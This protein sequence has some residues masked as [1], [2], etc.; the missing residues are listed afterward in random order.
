MATLL[1]LRL[2]LN[3]EIGTVTD[4]ETS[5]WSVTTRNNAIIDGYADLYRAGVWKAVT[6]S[7]STT[8]DI[9]LYALTTMRRLERVELLD[10]SSRVI[11]KP[12]AVIQDDGAGAWE[13]RLQSPLTT[14]YTIRVRG[15]TAYK[16][17]FVG[18][19]DTDDIPAEYNRVPLLKAKAILWRA[20]LGTFVRYGE[21]QALAPD[22]NISADQFLAMIAAAEREYET[23]AKKLSNLRPRSGQLRSL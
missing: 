13:L 1:A 3:G 16:S 10:A 19:G 8:T 7:F 20:Q 15:W 21:R 23:E 12:E 14:G 17:Q 4:A 9:W 18:D 11:E 22:M 5:P 2:K 6:Q